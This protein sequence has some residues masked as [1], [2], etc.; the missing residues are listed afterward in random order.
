M[1]VEKEAIDVI[2]LNRERT[3]PRSRRGD[4]KKAQ[5]K[6]IGGKHT[7]RG[8]VVGL[9]GVGK[10]KRLVKLLQKRQNWRWENPPC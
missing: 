6:K 9:D 3:L 7:S 2:L 10:T 1:G 4:E 5:N 8:T